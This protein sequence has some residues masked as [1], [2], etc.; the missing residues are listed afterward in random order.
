[1][2]NGLLARSQIEAQHS[3]RVLNEHAIRASASRRAN[4][5]ASWSTALASHLNR[6]ARQSGPTL[7]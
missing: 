6:S 1:M 5:R 7:D 2:L 3:E 4:R